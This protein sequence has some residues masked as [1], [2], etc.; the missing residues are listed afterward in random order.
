MSTTRSA[1]G[2]LFGTPAT[3]GTVFGR[4]GASIRYWLYGDTGIPMV[5]C[6]GLLSGV[7]TWEHFVRHFCRLYRVL[8]WEYPGHGFS[9]GEG[10]GN[11]AGI[12]MYAEDCSFLLEGV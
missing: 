11:G 3:T 4:K 2:P 5:L 1:N 9:V 10:P 7:N 12:D 6:N 8:L